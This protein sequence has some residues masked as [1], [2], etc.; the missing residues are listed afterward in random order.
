LQLHAKGL[1]VDIESLSREIEER[2]WRDANR[3][4]SPLVPAADAIQIDSTTMDPDA[5][6][7]AVLALAQAR[8]A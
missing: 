4:A 3:S 7:A 5:V 2:D 1:S 8:L 6:V